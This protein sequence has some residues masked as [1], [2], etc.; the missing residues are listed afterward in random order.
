MNREADVE[1]AREYLLGA[2]DER[3]GDLFEEAYFQGTEALEAVEAA[4]ETLIEDYLS[5]GLTGAERER[6]ERHY[7]AAPLR[8]TRVE[9]IRR[10]IAA[11]GHLA[12]PLPA[13]RAA[14]TRPMLAIAATLVVMAGASLWIAERSRQPDLTG[15]ARGESAASPSPESAGAVAATSFA[16]PVSPTT[17]RGAQDT[18]A[19]VVPPGTAVVDL[20]LEGEG[21]APP[22]PRGRVLIRTVAGDERWQ[23]PVVPSASRPPG[24]VAVAEVPAA[25][26]RADDYTITL[27]E[28][29]ASGAEY[30]R[31]RYFLRVRTQ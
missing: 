21:A 11:A 15:R 8:R 24:V 1:R 7:L 13:A 29:D 23:G 12:E 9:T 22:V 14:F 30:E 27:F 6:F 31:Y 20:Q 2:V 4:E 19:L 16:F 26:L 28:I 10:L 5:D 25:R 18:H 3:D 17:V